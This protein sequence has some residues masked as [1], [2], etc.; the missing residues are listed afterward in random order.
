MN[1]KK[2]YLNNNKTPGVLVFF[3]NFKIAFMNSSVP[4]FRLLQ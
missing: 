3:L 1:N 2:N 4:L